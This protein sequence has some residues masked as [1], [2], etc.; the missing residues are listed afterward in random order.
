MKK[1]LTVFLLLLASAVTTAQ[2][3][4]GWV[5]VSSEEGR[6]SVLMPTKPEESKETQNSPNGPY[7][8]HLLISKGAGEI[9]LVGWVDYDP[10][11]NFN[12]QGELEAN[13]DNFIKGIKA[14]LLDTVKI[15]FNGNPGIEFTAETADT[16][17]KSRIYVVGRRPYQLVVASPK[18]A[19]A[20][21]N[22]S[23]FFS[24]FEVT[25]AK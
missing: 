8:T 23:R 14:T 17:F 6:F 20:T 15:D 11:F 21:R 24:S 2:T 9:Y 7:T 5:K 12:V 16:S 13:R 4:G 10:N 19:D 22:I 1:A 18:G 25:A 3:P